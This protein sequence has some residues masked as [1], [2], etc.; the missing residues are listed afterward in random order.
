MFQAAAAG[1]SMYP[2]ALSERGDHRMFLQPEAARSDGG[3]EWT[4]AFCGLEY[5]DG[6]TCPL[7]SA[8]W[9]DFMSAMGESEKV[10]LQRGIA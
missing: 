7:E 8:H 10:T 9:E 6:E 4:C 5:R 2:S 1:L 3:S